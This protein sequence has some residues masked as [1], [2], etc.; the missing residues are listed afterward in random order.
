MHT[1]LSPQRIGLLMMAAEDLVWGIYPILAKDLTARFDPYLLAG[2]SGMAAGLPFMAFLAYKGLL[3]SITHPRVAL[4]LCM[5]ALTG[6][7]LP[8]LFFFTGAAQSSGINVALLGQVEPV[9]S[10]LLAGLVLREVI[11]R[12]QLFST[13]LLLLGAITVVYQ[14]GFRLQSGDLYLLIAP[15]WYQVGHL[16]AKRLFDDVAHVYVIPAVRMTLGGAIV[17]CVALLRKPELGQVLIDPS[18]MATLIA[19]GI[20]IVGAEKLF[21]YEA[22]KRLDLGRATALLV[23]SVGVGVVGA[24]W[25]LGEILKP[26]QAIGLLLMLTGLIVLTRD[27]LRHPRPPPS[28]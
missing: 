20:G 16:I 24:W 25:I 18:S 7:V 28:P 19:F 14:P 17:L 23:P 22:L 2:V 21:W 13:C 8:Y 5:V 11:T 1:R 26:M 27:G 15:F 9:Y 10:L 4:R 6:T 3:G 12:K